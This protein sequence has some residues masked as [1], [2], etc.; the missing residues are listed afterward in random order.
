[1]TLV[2]FFVKLDKLDSST[3]DTRRSRMLAAAKNGSK[4]A[5]K[6]DRSMSYK[7]KTPIPPATVFFAADSLLIIFVEFVMI[8][9]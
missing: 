3:I 5:K 7:Y 9:S 2:L 6:V 1:M 8:A 4:T